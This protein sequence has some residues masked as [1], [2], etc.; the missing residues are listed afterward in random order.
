MDQRL[1]SLSISSRSVM[2]KDGRES[3]SLEVSLLPAG[4]THTPWLGQGRST[5]SRCWRSRDRQSQHQCTCPKDRH[6]HRTHC[7]HSA[8]TG[9]YRQQRCSLG[10]QDN[11][12]EKDRAAAH[13]SDRLAASDFSGRRFRLFSPPVDLSR[14]GLVLL[15]SRS[16]VFSC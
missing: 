4:Y 13:A 3:V 7:A 8:C 6:R 5:A 11:Q 2:I 12:G 1:L 14:T 16:P 15:A 10:K 9:R